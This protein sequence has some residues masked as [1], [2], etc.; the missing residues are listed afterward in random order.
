M[1]LAIHIE[2]LIIR[3]AMYSDHILIFIVY[4]SYIYT[5]GV[6]IFYVNSLLVTHSNGTV[7]IALNITLIIQYGHRL[8]GRM[9]KMKFVMVFFPLIGLS[10]SI[11]EIQLFET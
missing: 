6:F 4:V 5:P 9:C 2:F 1:I 11:S 10:Y 7:R 3:A 8:I